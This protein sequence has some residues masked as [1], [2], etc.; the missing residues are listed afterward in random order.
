MKRPSAILALALALATAAADPQRPDQASS[1]GSMSRTCE[2]VLTQRVSGCTEAMF[3]AGTCSSAC[4]D[5]LESMEEA[6]QEACEGVKGGPGF[7]R[8]ALGGRLVETTCRKVEE[9]E[10]EED[11]DDEDEEPTTTAARGRDVETPTPTPTPSS[12]TTGSQPTGR[13]EERS[14]ESEGR[15]NGVGG[16]PFDIVAGADALRPAGWVVVAAGVLLLVR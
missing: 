10:E 9:E 15:P 7:L 14:E 3:G 11:D 12:S 6:L 1:R 4:A 8:A 13:S 2:R 5:G 16:S